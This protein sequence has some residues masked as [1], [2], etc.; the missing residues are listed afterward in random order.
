MPALLGRIP[1]GVRNAATSTLPCDAPKPEP[2]RVTERPESKVAG[3]IA[4]ML[5]MASR[6]REHTAR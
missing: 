6:Q 5:G 1:V 3:V 4:L 2:V